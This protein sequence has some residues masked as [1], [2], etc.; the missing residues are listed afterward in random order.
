[1]LLEISSWTP[2]KTVCS[3]HMLLG[4]V[5]VGEP[6]ATA[7]TVTCPAPLAV[8]DLLQGDDTGD[9]G[10]GQRPMVVL[11]PK[12]NGLTAAL[13]SVVQQA[14]TDEPMNAAADSEEPELGSPPGFSRIT[15]PDEETDESR[16]SA[17]VKAVQRKIQSPL[18]TKPIKTKL[19]APVLAAGELPKRSERLGN[20]PLANVASSKHAEVILMRRFEEIPEA[21]PLTTEAKQAYKKFYVEE[22][23]EKHYE[24]IQEHRD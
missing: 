12:T 23:R 9:I 6:A 22:M 4:E 20:H 3:G 11:G 7:A 8:G 17:F 14:G 19:V 2:V 21:A 18:L 15:I 24:A 5:E 1:M 10:L 13:A 16:L